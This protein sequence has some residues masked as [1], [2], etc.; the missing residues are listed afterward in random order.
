MSDGSFRIG[1]ASIIVS[2]GMTVT[3]AEL[4]LRSIALDGV[5]QGPEFDVESQRFSFDHHGDC[6]RLVTSA[7]CR[8]VLDAILLGLEPSEFTVYVNDVD[9][10]TVLAVA[11]LAYPEWLVQDGAT[12]T[13]VRRLVEVVGSR[14]AHGPA[15]PVADRA[16]LARFAEA[17][18]LP[19]RRSG[20]TV[21]KMADDLTRGV[22]GVAALVGDLAEAM[23]RET[24]PGFGDEQRVA[25]DRP[26]SAFV[27]THS[28]TGWAMATSDVDALDEGY[29]RGFHRLVMW[30]GLDDGSTAYTVARR[31]DLVGGFPVG[32]AS[33][34]GTI[35]AALAAR[36]PGWGG[37]T[38]IGGAP[39]HP[40][41][42]RSA[43]SPSEVFHIVE[44]VVA[45]LR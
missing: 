5:V 4:P 30:R 37:G 15:Y 11:L 13:M 39:R 14:D 29:A 35:L 41:G 24:R 26:S 20:V 22:A 40:D 21:A 1:G 27:V 45:A 43:L 28:G 44:G 16:L 12:P 38:S 32:P 33:R 23:D 17:V 7:T 19:V 36:E 10:D 9:A 6:V 34:P 8:Q 18:A 25:L 3:L 42:R 31:S 2:L